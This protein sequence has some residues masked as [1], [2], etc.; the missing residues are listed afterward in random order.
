MTTTNFIIAP[1][2]PNE[3]WQT[4]FADRGYTTPQASID[5]G[6]PYLVQPTAQYGSWVYIK[7]YG[8]VIASTLVK[9][10]Y[11]RTD[12]VGEISIRTHLAYSND[13]V[14]Y[15]ETQDVAQI[16]ALNF[17]YI[18]VTFEFG[19]LPSGTPMGMLAAITVDDSGA[20][21]SDKNFSIIS[22]IR[23]RLDSKIIKDSGFDTVSVAAT[24]K[25]VLFNK[26][27]I[28]IRSIVVSARG[29]GSALITP[30][31]DFTDTPNPTQF[32][33]YLLN[34]AGTKITG[35]FSWHAEGI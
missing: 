25:V 11:L 9:L 3:T 23:L 28:D 30:I 5:A 13:G 32:T 33:V 17:R 1:V 24:G 12:V 21:W 4:R 8:A 10:S 19:T 2:N 18:R 27:F 14:A 26:A 35:D 31:Y 15:T 22:E 16:Y 34:S 20:V 29:D 7:D 6:Y